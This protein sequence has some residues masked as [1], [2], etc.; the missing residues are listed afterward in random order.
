[1]TE[2]VAIDCPNCIDGFI[3]VDVEYFGRKQ[4]IVRCPDCE[5]GIKEID[6][7]ESETEERVAA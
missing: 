6:V 2:V 1:M 3:E 4:E 5:G 7:E